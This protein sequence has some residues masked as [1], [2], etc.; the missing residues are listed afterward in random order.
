MKKKLT[1][2]AADI[3]VPVK[4]NLE[5]NEVLPKFCDVAQIMIF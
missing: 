2:Y 5:G 1:S 3:S 4:N